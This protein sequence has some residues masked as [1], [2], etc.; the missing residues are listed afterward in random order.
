M[1]WHNIAYKNRFLETY[2]HLF[3]CEIITP[4][5]FIKL[6][7]VLHVA[8]NC[9]PFNVWFVLKIDIRGVH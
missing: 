5:F 3:H 6:C 9:D 8:Q 7:Q 1:Y 4:L 2:K